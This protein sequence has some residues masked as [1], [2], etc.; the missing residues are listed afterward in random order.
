[1]SNTAPAECTEEQLE[2]LDG[3]RRTGAVNMF[4]ASPYL[5]EAFALKPAIAREIIMHWM[6]TFGDRHPNE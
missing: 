3:L 1:M 2:F 5:A 6:Y 4:A